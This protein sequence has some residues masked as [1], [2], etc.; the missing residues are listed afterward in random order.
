[1]IATLD[2]LFAEALSL[3]DDIRLQL[4][5]RLILTI[6]TEATLETEQIQEVQR[7][8]NDVRLGRVETIPGEKVF[9]E[10]EQ[11]LASRRTA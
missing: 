5:E 8:M 1:M 6:Q 11:S 7:R 2:T 3:S 4:V 9:R 10:I